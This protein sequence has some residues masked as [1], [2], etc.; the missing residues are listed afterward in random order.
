MQRAAAMIREGTIGELYSFRGEYLRSSYIDPSRSVRWKGDAAQRGGSFD[1]LGSHLLD[2]FTW[3]LGMPEKLVAQKKTL[4]PTRRSANGQVS[5]VTSEDHAWAFLQYPQGCIGTL[6]TS[7]VSA[8]RIN[9]VNIEITGSKGALKWEQTNPNYL[10]FA[11]ASRPEKEISWLQLPVFQDYPG[12]VLPGADYPVG[13]MRYHIASAASFIQN[14]VSGS[15]YQPGLEQAYQVQR[16]LD[17]AH[18]SAQ[19]ANQWV[20]LSAYE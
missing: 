9:D 18:D 17:A 5:Q 16:V 13:M 10:Y 6:E 3:M 12:A 11:D 20:E 8:G 1:D 14:T 4:V 7:R 19:K 2:L 15:P